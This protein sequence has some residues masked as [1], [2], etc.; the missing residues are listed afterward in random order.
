MTNPIKVPAFGKFLNQLKGA[1]VR[2]ESAR[3]FWGGVTPDGEIVVTAWIDQNDGHGRFKIWR[4][5]TNHGRLKEQWEVGNIRVGTE[6]R[7]ILIRQ[8][9]NVPSGKPGRQVG[10]AALMP[11][12]WRVA[13]I[14]RDGKTG[15]I[16]PA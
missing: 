15:M 2:T 12:K 4:P 16:E 5:H 13:E 10:A 7:V 6:V 11:E 9:G 8:R 3:G 14:A 1:G